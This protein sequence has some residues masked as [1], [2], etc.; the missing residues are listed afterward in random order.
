MIRTE[1]FD[2]ATV[3]IDQKA[4]GRYGI[5]VTPGAGVFVPTTAWETG[6]PLEL[7]EHVLRTKGPVDL[8]D[9]IRR[10]EDPVCV[11]H[12]FRWSILSYV[13]AEDFAGR[14]VLDFG[15]GC[16]ASAMVLGRLLPPT[17]EITGVDLR[18]DYIDLARH[19]A[20]VSGSEDRARSEHE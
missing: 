10:D 3:N 18:D 17:T 12:N 7:I 15:C 16:G 9:E 1:V 4:G 6:Y 14:R 2:E 8:C 20:Q 13:R 5:S 19:R 11:E